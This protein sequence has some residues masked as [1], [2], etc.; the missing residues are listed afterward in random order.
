MRDLLKD[1][2]INLLCL[3]PD[4]RHRVNPGIGLGKKLQSRSRHAVLR[5]PDTI[6][7][8]FLWCSERLSSFDLAA[9][10]AAIF[11]AKVR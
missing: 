10:M 8:K 7:G 1:L 2:S 3:R 11:A 4:P 6:G 9:D 5:Y